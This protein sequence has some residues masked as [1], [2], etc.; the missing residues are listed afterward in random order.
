MCVCV[1]IGSSSATWLSNCDKCAFAILPP[2]LLAVFFSSG[3]TLPP[4]LVI[5]LV[6]CLLKRSVAP[7][8]SD[9]LP[10]VLPLELVKITLGATHVVNALRDRSEHT[11]DIHVVKF[12]W[13]IKNWNGCRERYVII[14]PTSQ[15]LRASGNFVKILSL[16]PLP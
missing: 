13:G 10:S 4:T 11:S 8:Q 5:G 12:E 6:R 14:L 15:G 16:L 2:P 1:V 3:L 9:S 7:A